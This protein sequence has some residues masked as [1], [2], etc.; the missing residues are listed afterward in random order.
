MRRDEGE[1]VMGKDP[2]ADWIDRNLQRQRAD[3]MRQYVSIG[4]G[5]TVIFVLLCSF[6]CL[7]FEALVR[8]VG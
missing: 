4:V 5:I 7:I 8:M 2:I 6:S 1:R 3:T